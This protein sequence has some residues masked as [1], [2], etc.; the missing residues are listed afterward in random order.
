LLIVDNGSTDATPDI[1][2]SLC[3]RCPAVRYLHTET[4]GVGVAF[5]MGLASSTADIVGYVD[6]DLSTDPHYLTDV[7]R[8]FSEDADA[9]IVQATRYGKGARVVGRKWYRKPMSAGLMALLRHTFD[10]RVSDA[11]G[12]FKFFRRETALRLAAE[13]GGDSGESSWFF[14]IE[15][16]VRAEREGLT[17]REIPV[18][19]VDDPNTSVRYGKVISNYLKQIRS[20]RRRLAGED[21]R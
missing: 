10:L 14:L 5:R 4:R 13:A 6:I 17:I 3:E 2:Q 20:L 21:S 12:G 7:L 19:W 8:I 15:M 16:L 18:V 1:A 9:Q 11:I